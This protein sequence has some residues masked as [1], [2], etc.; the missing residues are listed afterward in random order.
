M[1]LIKKI[2][3]WYKH[4]WKH[5]GGCWVIPKKYAITQRECERCGRYQEICQDHVFGWNT[6]ELELPKRPT[7]DQESG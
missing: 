7:Q 4:D 2:L 3:C 5:V 6:L 1:S